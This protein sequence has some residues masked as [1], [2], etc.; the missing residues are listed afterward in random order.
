MTNESLQSDI[1]AADPVPQVQDVQLRELVRAMA[2]Q[3]RATSLVGAAHRTPWWKR[4]RIVIPLGAIGVAA[5]TGA[6]ILIPFGLAINGTQVQ[7]DAEIPINYTTD[8]GIDIS[9]RYG[10]YFGDPANRTPAD[11]QLAE[12]VENHDWTG[13]GQRIY[14]EAMDQPFVP[15]PNDNWEVDT[16]ELRDTHTFIL[17]SSRVIWAEIPAELQQQS[18]T[19]SSTSDCTGQLR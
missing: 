1:S 9:C 15:G 2:M 12:F 11:E 5:L 19:A 17:A 6:A 18:L 7:L 3:A 13:I 10:I 4:G 14:S 8:N 16:Q